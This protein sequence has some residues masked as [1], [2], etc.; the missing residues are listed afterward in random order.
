VANAAAA[1][2]CGREKEEDIDIEIGEKRERER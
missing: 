1:N 2:K